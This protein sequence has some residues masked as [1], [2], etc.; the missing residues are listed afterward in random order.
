MAHA[1]QSTTRGPRTRFT[2]ALAFAGLLVVGWAFTGN[3]AQARIASMLAGPTAVACIDIDSVLSQLDERAKFE[4]SLVSLAATLENEVNALKAS[5]ESMQGDLDVYEP[6]TDEFKAIRRQVDMSNA[7]WRLQAELANRTIME[8]RSDLQR[9]LY[10]KIMD[11]ARAYAQ[12]EGW[13]IVLVNDSGEEVPRGLTSEQFS[14]FI[15]T[16]SVAYHANTVDISDAVATAL[17]NAYRN[18]ASP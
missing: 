18:N 14:A 9:N 17:N 5:A 6:G 10:V 13:D 12:A 8:E 7:S 11:G 1:D 15:S 3:A 2:A 16:R 4:E